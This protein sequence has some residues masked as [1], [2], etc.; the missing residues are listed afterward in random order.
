[1]FQTD[2]IC[3]LPGLSEVYVCLLPIFEVNYNNSVNV[4]TC[5]SSQTVDELISM[6][7]ESFSITQG[8]AQH[9]F[10]LFLPLGDSSMFIKTKI[11]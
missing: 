10:E 8:Q 7:M 5:S 9:T 1:M 11:Q 6:A 2:Q 4:I 3:F